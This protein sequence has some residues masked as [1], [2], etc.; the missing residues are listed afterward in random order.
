MANKMQI[1][2]EDNSINVSKEVAM[3]WN[4]ANKLRGPYKSDKY[5]DVIIPMIIIYRHLAS[6]ILILI[7]NII[8]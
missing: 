5:K 4:I 8:S 1:M 3:V 6:K 7:R 2:W